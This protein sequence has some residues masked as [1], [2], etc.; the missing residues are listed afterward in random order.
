MCR[1]NVNYVRDP[2]RR[3]RCVQVPSPPVVPAPQPQE[4]LAKCLNDH[5]RFTA[6]GHEQLGKL[7]L[8]QAD[9]VNKVPKDMEAFVQ[10]LI[11]DY[12]R[13]V[14]ELLQ[15][16]ILEW[17][18]IVEPCYGRV[19]LSRPLYPRRRFGQISTL[20]SYGDASS[21]LTTR[22]SVCCKIW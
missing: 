14:D 3:T 2:H 12:G 16:D 15:D 10:T 9:I 6:R 1:K 21:R 7:L 18:P 5:W 11:S 20:A 4:P 19:R 8:A 22:H 13:T 17:F